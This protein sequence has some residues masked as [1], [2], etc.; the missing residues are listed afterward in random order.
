MALHG[1][2][3]VRGDTVLRRHDRHDGHQRIS[4]RLLPGR[5]RRGQRVDHSQPQ[6][7]RLHGNVHPDRMGHAARPGESLWH[8]SRHHVRLHLLN[9]L[10]AVVWETDEAVARPD[11]FWG[12]EVV[13][14]ERPRPT[15]Y[16]RPK[17]GLLESIYVS[18]Q[19]YLNES[20]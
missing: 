19:Y 11:V 4:A 13:F 10:L 14:G 15:A 16:S 1:D 17:R 6:L 8:P 20:Q 2:R 7:G 3:R 18:R 5:L 12:W 9:G